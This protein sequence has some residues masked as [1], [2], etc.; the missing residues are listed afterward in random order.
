MTPTITANLFYAIEP[1]GGVRAY[2]RVN[3]DPITG[4]KQRNYERGEK[5]RNYEREEK[6]VIIENVR[7][8]EDSLTLDT[9][10]FQ[11]YKHTS[12]HTTFANDEEIRNEYYPESTEIIKKL[13]GANRVEI[14][15]HKIRHRRPGEGESDELSQPAAD[16]HVDQTTA[17]AI[18]QVHKHLPAEASKLLERRCQI[19]NLWRPIDNPAV[20][21]PF[22]SSSFKSRDGHPNVLMRAMVNTGTTS[23]TL[24]VKYNENHKWKYLHGMT[25]EEFVLIKCFDSIQDGS[26]AIYTPHSAFDDPTTPEGTPYRKSIELRALVFYD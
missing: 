1:D 15:D 25:P 14:F 4:E 23:E 24:A 12:K 18:A 13:T 26:V 16:A 19:I 10:G 22:S 9:A 21:W 5:K 17:A 3:A 8:K 20:D 11:F 6:S 7:G 2:H